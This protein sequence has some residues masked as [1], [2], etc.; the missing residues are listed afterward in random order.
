MRWGSAGPPSPPS[1]FSWDKGHEQPFRCWFQE[2]V[3]LRRCA[4]TWSARW[5]AVTSTPRM[6]KVGPPEPGQ[7]PLCACHLLLTQGS[8]G[9]LSCTPLHHRG[10]EG[11]GGAHLWWGVERQQSP[12]RGAA[13]HPP[14][15]ACMSQVMLFVC[16]PCWQ[17]GPAFQTSVF[18]ISLQDSFLNL[19][20]THCLD[21]D[22]FW[23]QLLLY[24]AQT[25]LQQDSREQL[26]AAGCPEHEAAD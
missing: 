14:S 9:W 7:P 25:V 5:L 23:K 4:G 11:R 22:T 15:A 26:L 17:N 21:F 19:F 20:S 16:W 3:L 6:C 10:R 13:P 18:S 8:P 24:F 12:T 1:E 2:A